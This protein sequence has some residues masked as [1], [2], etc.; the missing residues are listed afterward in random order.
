[1][2]TLIFIAVVIGLYVGWEAVVNN[3][4]WKYKLTL[5]VETPEGLKTGSAVRKVYA[6]RDPVILQFLPSLVYGHASV[7]GEAVLV[8]LGERGVLFALLK[9]KDNNDYGYNIIF[10]E[11][12]SGVRGGTT[13]EGI[14]FYSNLKAKKDLDFDKIPMLVRFR[15]IN[16]PKSVELVDPSDLEKTF[17]K[18]VKLVSATLEMTDDAVTSGIDKWL[19]WFNKWQEH[20][21]NIMGKEYFEPNLP[22]LPPETFLIPM[23]FM[24]E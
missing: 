22:P 14:K 7:K 12:P 16:D 23:N 1:M 19:P 11:F 4:S 15:D 5:V 8:D 18:G 17:G 6:Y 2:K 24:Q 21:G 3:G 13:P 10:S 9:G 20:G